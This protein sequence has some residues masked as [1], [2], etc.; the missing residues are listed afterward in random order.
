MTYFKGRVKV[1][2]I[3]MVKFN[4]AISNRFKIMEFS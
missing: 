3:Y 2:N 4:A 1:V